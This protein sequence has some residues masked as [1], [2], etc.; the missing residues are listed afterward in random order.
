MKMPTRPNGYVRFFTPDRALVQRRARQLSAL[1]LSA[2]LLGAC[3]GNPLMQ[4]P[5]NTPVSIATATAVAMLTP[6]AEPPTAT[7]IPCADWKES[8]VQIV[9]SIFVYVLTAA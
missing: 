6:T 1:V 9:I 2:A 7:A 8:V 5:T 4:D 3:G